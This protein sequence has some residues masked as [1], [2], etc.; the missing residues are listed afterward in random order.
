M[1][2]C[3]FVAFESG[4]QLTADF[5]VFNNG[6]KSGCPPFA[7][8]FKST[9][10]GTSPSTTY[11]WNFGKPPISTVGAVAATTYFAPGT[12]TVTLTI[13]DGG[14]S[15]F[16]TKTA[17]I[18]VHDTPTV[19]F[20]A[21]PVNGCP[22][23]NVN[24]S[25]SSTSGAGGGANTYTWYFG[26]PPSSTATNPSFS[27]GTPGTYNVSLQAKNQFGCI[28]TKTKPS[29]I[30]VSAKPTANFTGSPTIACAP[31]LIV[32]FAGSAT[33]G[34]S[35]YTYTWDLGSP[36]AAAV[37]PNPPPHTYTGWPQ[38]YN[39]KLIVKD[40]NGCTDS[41][42]K[43]NYVQ[44]L[45]VDAA[46]TGPTN[47]CVGTPLTFTNNSTPQPTSSSWTFGSAGSS[48]ATSPTF[49]FHNPGTYNVRLIHNVNGCLDTAYQTVTIL[50][51]PVVTFV[52]KP[53]SPCPAPQNIQLIPSGSFSAYSWDFGDN[54]TPGTTASPF[55]IYQANGYYTPTLTVTD[56]NGC[57]DTVTKTDLV[58]L[59]DLK[60]TIT[61]SDT[62][63]CVPL[64]IKFKVEDSTRTPGNI[65]RPY[66]YDIKSVVWD[67]GVT[68]TF[69]TTTLQP[70]YT[71]T[72][73]GKYKPSVIVTTNNGCIAK[74]TLRVKAGLLP[75]A[76]FTASRTR[77][78]NRKTIGFT[79]TSVDN[80]IDEWIWDYGDGGGDTGKLVTHQYNWPG[81]YSVRLVVGCNGCYDTLI[82]K[83]Y[84]QVDSPG[85]S[86]G[87]ASDC[88][89]RSR[90][91]F[92][93]GSVGWDSLRWSFGDGNTSTVENPAHIYPPVAASYS[94]RLVTFNNTTGCSDTVINTVPVRYPT[95]TVVSDDTAICKNDKARFTATLQ[96]INASK[97]FWYINNIFYSDS[98]INYT[99]QFTNTGIYTIKVAV[100]D[101]DMCTDTATR[102][103]YQLVS[104]PAAAFS[105]SPVSG[106]VPLT[107]NFTDNSTAFTNTTLVN[108][109]WEFGQPPSQS[110]PGATASATYTV[111]GTYNVKLVV[112]DNVGCS[113]S[114]TKPAY[115]NAYKPV[116]YFN[117]KDSACV[118][119]VV[120]FNNVSVNYDSVFWDFGDN[121]GI[122]RN[123]PATHKY[124]AP[125]MYTVKLIARDAYGCRDTMTVVNKVDVSKPHADFTI[126]DT[127]TACPIFNAV[128]TNTSTGGYTYEWKLGSGNTINNSFHANELF[129]TP[130]YYTIRLIVTNKT[131]CSDTAIKHVN[132]LG[133]SG[134]LSYT[135]LKGCNP[136]EVNFN[137]NINN[138]TNLLWDF[139]DGVVIPA[140]PGPISH[141]Y[142]AAG[143]YVPRLIITDDKGCTAYTIGKD[144]IKVDEIDAD[145][146][147]GPACEYSS[148][149]MLDNSKSLF[150]YTSNWKWTFHDGSVSTQSK[151]AY[152]Y[153][154]AGTYPV[155]LLVINN[156][157]CIDS[158]EKNITINKL[159]IISAGAD[160]VI[161]L[162]DSAALYP[163]GGVTY[164]WSP[165][166]F[167]RC[168]ACGNTMAAPL[169]KSQY[170]VVGTDA[171]GCKNTD[172]VEISIKTKVTSVAGNGGDICDLDTFQLGA[173]GA[174]SYVWSPDNTLNAGNIPNPVAKPSVTTSYKVIGYE[175]S[176]I[177][178]TDIVN[179]VVHPRPTVKA[180]GEA[181]II[182][183]TT[184]VL[185]SSGTLIKKFLWTP[186][187]SLSCSDCPDP[188]A[189]PTKTTVYTI[190]AYTEF[191]C[192]D[193]DAVKVTVLCDES[194]LFIP[195]TFTPNGDGQNDVFFPRGDGIDKVKSVR[196]YN[197]WGEIVFE[198][199]GISLNDQSSGWDGTFRGNELPPDVF[200]YLIEVICDGG[201]IMKLKGDITLIR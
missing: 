32:N 126:N 107:V 12:Y 154:A 102:F 177:P 14:K 176:C 37:G 120:A 166:T 143:A 62:Q 15:S 43:V 74:D 189:S 109:Y 147:S 100:L 59:H 75:T 58:Q 48:P 104:K 78:C 122:Y 86:F 182:S 157:G 81:I 180:L 175:G 121:T 40:V 56:N 186:A 57:K 151:P 135:P 155:K 16:K 129:T 123:V 67:M 101:D 105:G 52:S 77:I 198:K 132:V 179:I 5:E 23:L 181:T 178:D 44:V 60:V 184:T 171:N 173:K 161:C 7:V 164:L 35:P 20:N 174:R 71:Y 200:V 89:I 49:T 38:N 131:G 146:N 65:I 18:T 25:N 27:Y 39:V 111:G 136:L 97:Y 11:A 116:A 124:A 149:E 79:G 144:T 42:T 30:S 103:N 139:N 190:K 33:G 29:Y 112:T 90:K 115:I 148:V 21:T 117:S 92:K 66:P 167:L 114:L 165:A 127:V 9:S 172:S 61:A 13:S 70:N 51:Q 140:P 3:M 87:Y 17:Y 73:P 47:A 36:P 91:L 170:V 191:G 110:L 64:P 130:G 125:G 85:A 160:T 106:C 2:I 8:T 158:I 68:P 141:T 1:L 133:Y 84:I 108:R 88:L 96:G 192:V 93:S 28:S 4:A 199:S 34:Q 119:E 95:L 183:G 83:D 41:V 54:T 10:T 76:S 194:Q 118:N 80:C 145:F 169:T 46:F 142:T 156:I 162:K 137:S 98:V 72:N 55:H 197:R 63:G 19:N 185:Q 22:P 195:N 128:Y 152:Q 94:V 26:P 163:T 168:S 188:T 50:P 31:P 150:G 193:S 6:A 69:T 187:Q 138:L 82:K 53:D 134:S 45:K 201:E 99:H 153:G 196:I 24:F 159:P 113:D